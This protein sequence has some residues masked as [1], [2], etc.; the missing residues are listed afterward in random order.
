LTILRLLA[1]GP[2]SFTEVVRATGLSKST[3][4]HHMVMLR[5]A[6]LVRVQDTASGTHQGHPYK[7]VTYVLRPDAIDDLADRLHEYLREE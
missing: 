2:H 3:V 4:N 1:E 7:P 5:A 6:G